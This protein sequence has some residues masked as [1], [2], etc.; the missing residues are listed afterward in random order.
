MP[1]CLVSLGTQNTL[2]ALASVPKASGYVTLAAFWQLIIELQL[3]VGCPV[4]FLCLLSSVTWCSFSNIKQSEA[5]TLQTSWN[6]RGQA[7]RRKPE[8]C[9]NSCFLL[10]VSCLLTQ[11]VYGLLWLQCFQGPLSHVRLKPAASLLAFMELSTPGHVWCAWIIHT[12]LL[13]SFLP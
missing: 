3:P 6:I 9:R 7:V 13:L 11:S 4:S 2:L 12:S 8:M 10:K 5:S 1:H